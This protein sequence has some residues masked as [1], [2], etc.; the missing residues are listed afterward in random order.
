MPPRQRR[1]SIDPGL[2]A[3]CMKCL[4]KAVERRYESMGQLAEDLQRHLQGAA[5]QPSH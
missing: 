2:E 1:D 3:I 4:E 5:G